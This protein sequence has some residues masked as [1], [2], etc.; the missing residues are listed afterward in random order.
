M[1]LQR[2]IVEKTNTFLDETTHITFECAMHLHGHRNKVAPLMK[3]AILVN[4]SNGTKFHNYICWS[5]N[6]T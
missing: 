2:S 4:L 1:T 3:T 5:T 6:D